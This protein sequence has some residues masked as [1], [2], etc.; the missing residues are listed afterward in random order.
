MLKEEKDSA[1][2]MPTRCL[3]LD[4]VSFSLFVTACRDSED[5]GSAFREKRYVSDGSQDNEAYAFEKGRNLNVIVVRR[6][7]TI[8]QHIEGPRPI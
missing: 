4:K 8:F 1:T 6:T 5:S 7:Q 2:L 3:R